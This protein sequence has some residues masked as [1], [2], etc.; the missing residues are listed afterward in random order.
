MTEKQGQSKTRT[1]LSKTA[2]YTD[3]HSSRVD[4]YCS[5]KQS[6]I[7]VCV[8]EFVRALGTKTRSSLVISNLRQCTDNPQAG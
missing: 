5:R 7:F 1:L 6:V 8:E 2:Q 3:L 4:A